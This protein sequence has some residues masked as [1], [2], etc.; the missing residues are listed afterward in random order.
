VGAER[1]L[2]RSPGAH[3]CRREP[4]P[5]RRENLARGAR[6]AGADSTRYV[7]IENWNGGLAPD[8]TTHLLRA[9]AADWGL[10]LDLT[11]LKPPAIHGEN[12]VSQK[13]EGLGHASHYY[14][15]TRLAT[16]GTL[17][18]GGRALAVTGQ[19]WMDH[20]F[21][22][23]GLGEG[24]AGWDWFSVQLDDGRE[25]MLYQ[26]RRADGTPEPHSSGTLIARDGRTT[27]LALADFTIAATGKWK[28]PHTGAEYPAGWVVRVPAEQLELTLT[29]LV[30]DQELATT[31]AAGVTYWEGAVRVAGSRR[32]SSALGAMATS[33]S[34]ATRADAGILG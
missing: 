28:S 22:S 2:L 7:W 16:T 25:L 14:S 3:R 33:N 32:A 21:S 27:H 34:P 30:A 9:S 5:L 17:T 15:L 20:E 8:D 31:S 12:G 23:G 6:L 10:A 18:L 4:L 13:S 26:M 19:S 11:P 1:T 29:P 24:L